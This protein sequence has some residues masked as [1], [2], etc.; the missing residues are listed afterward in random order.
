M[1]SQAAKTMFG[2]VFS[3]NASTRLNLASLLCRVKEGT[4]AI[5]QATTGG[6]VLP[7]TDLKV[8]FIFFNSLFVSVSPRE[9]KVTGD[10]ME[11]M[12]AR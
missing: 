2:F 12:G 5:R 8:R 9:T 7:E 6:A 1:R 3:V 11:S 10:E 4:K